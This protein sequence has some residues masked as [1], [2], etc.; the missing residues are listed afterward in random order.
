[1]VYSNYPI[2]GATH[3]MIS[4]SAIDC[5]WDTWVHGECSKTCGFGTR[6]NNRTKLVEEEN[7]GTCT[8]QSSEIED[9]NKDPCPSTKTLSIQ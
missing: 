4:Y 2:N 6:T 7:G 5:K 1:M 9:C 3:I 8:G